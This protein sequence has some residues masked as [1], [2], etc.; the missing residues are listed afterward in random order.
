MN[1]S[2]RVHFDG[3]VYTVPYAL[4]CKRGLL[5]K[6]TATTVDIYY[7]NEL[8]AS[9]ARSYDRGADVIYEMTHCFV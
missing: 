5:L 3:N 6:A 7:Q 8:V 4:A 1:G 2:Y 9:H